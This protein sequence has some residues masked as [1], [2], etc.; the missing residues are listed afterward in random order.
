MI[1]SAHVSGVASNAVPF[2][3]VVI[4]LNSNES[5][6][7]LVW[8]NLLCTQYKYTSLKYGLNRYPAHISF[9]VTGKCVPL[10][11]FLFIIYNTLSAC[12]DKTFCTSLLLYTWLCNSGGSWNYDLSGLR[13]SFDI[14]PSWCE[15]SSSHQIH[16]NTCSSESNASVSLDI[17]V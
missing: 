16:N 10:R 3:G 4:N 17:S 2:S 1:L 11:T 12:L 7:A 15:E 14:T 13:Y 6:D 5:M 8:D 9:T